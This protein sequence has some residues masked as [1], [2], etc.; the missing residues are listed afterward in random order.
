M[1]RT[2][3]L[4]EDFTCGLCP[5]EG[6][7]VGVVVFEVVHDGMLQ[8]GDAFENAAAIPTRAAIVRRLQCVA[9]GGFSLK[10]RYTTCLIFLADSG[11]R[12]GGRVAS[13]NSPS[14]PFAAYRR[15]QRRTVSTLL[16]T[17]RAMTP[18][19][20]PSPANKTIR[21][22]HTTF[23]GV[24]RSLTSFS[25]HS[26]SSGGTRMR[27]IVPMRPESHPPTDLGIIRCDQKTSSLSDWG[28]DFRG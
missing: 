6:L 7:G 12:P 19:F 1:F 20:V 27:S 22:R 26:R 2:C 14:T 23:C 21:A 16:P 25:S 11:L 15:R 3:D 24:L 17:L 8:L 10:V 28:F 4:F 5:D 9:F 18:A 13:L